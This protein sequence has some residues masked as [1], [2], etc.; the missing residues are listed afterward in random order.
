MHVFLVLLPCWSQSGSEK[1]VVSRLCS[2]FERYSIAVMRTVVDCSVAHSSVNIFS[3]HKGVLDCGLRIAGGARL[4]VKKWLCP[5]E[6]FL[7]SATLYRLDG[8]RKVTR[9][10]RYEGTKNVI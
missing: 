10:E 2:L 3:V 4:A 6:I 1:V 8:D 7:S 9:N 5:W